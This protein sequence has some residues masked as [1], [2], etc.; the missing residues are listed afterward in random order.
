[1]LEKFRSYMLALRFYREIR[2]LR[3]PAH[4]KGQLERAASSV[5]LCLAEGYGRSSPADKRRF[6]HM[7]MGSMRE[8]QAVL[9]LATITSP[10]LLDL[11]D[12]LAASIY[13]LTH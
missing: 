8:S 2:G 13:K 6:Y 3:L 12:H 1:M 9:A 5:A 10:L 11:A 7:A 4:L